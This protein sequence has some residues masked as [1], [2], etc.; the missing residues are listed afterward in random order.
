MTNELVYHRGMSI[1]QRLREKRHD[2]GLT[3]GQVG[4]HEGITAQYLSDLERGKNQP[5]TWSLLARLAR[6]YQTSADYLLGLEDAA[7]AASRPEIAEI[8]RI[9][10]ELDEEQR[11]LVHDMMAMLHKARTPRIV[12]G[13]NEEGA[14]DAVQT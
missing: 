11:T 8:V 2:A 1:G 4:E 14:E 3:L 5:N 7:A 6:R 12:G 10:L 13:Q 9:W